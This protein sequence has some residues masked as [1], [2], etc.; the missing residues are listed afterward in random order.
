[1]YCDK[2]KNEEKNTIQILFVVRIIFLMHFFVF[3]CF[4]IAVATFPAQ[5]HF[6]Q[7]LHLSI[8]DINQ[9]WK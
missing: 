5:K 9:I 2:T 1:M 3:I 4:H 7:V 6:E 8:L